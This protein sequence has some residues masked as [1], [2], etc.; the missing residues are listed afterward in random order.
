MGIG[1][2]GT[3]A[4]GV[5]APTMIS[6]S[7]GPDIEQYVPGSR[8]D[9]MSDQITL[10]KGIRGYESGTSVHTGGTAKITNTGYNVGAGE[11]N[12]SVQLGAQRHS[13]LGLTEYSEFSSWTTSPEVAQ[14]YAGDGGSILQMTTSRFNSDLVNVQNLIA[15]GIDTASLA[16]SVGMSAID[17]R[18]INVLNNNI[19]VAPSMQ[20]YLL[21]VRVL[22]E[23]LT[24][25]YVSP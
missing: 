5:K 8:P 14:M 9:V 16:E 2:L 19:A 23:T 6:D 1:Q 21:R 18:F 24:S 20:E 15:N 4:L 13:L 7:F 17:Q 10:Y 3:K 22:A 12:Y 11:V 25:V